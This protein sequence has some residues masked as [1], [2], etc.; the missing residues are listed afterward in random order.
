MASGLPGLANRGSEVCQIPSSDDGFAAYTMRTTLQRMDTDQSTPFE[1]YT[2]GYFQTNAYALPTPG[3]RR[4]RA[5][6]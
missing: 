6:S 5:N 2:G 3:G 4:R 1:K